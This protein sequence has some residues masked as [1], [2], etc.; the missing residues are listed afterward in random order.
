MVVSIIAKTFF[1]ARHG[2]ETLSQLIW[3]D[4]YATYNGGMLRILRKAIISDKPK[5]TYR[6]LMLDTARNFMPIQ[7]LRRVLDGMSSSKLNVFHWHIS[8]SQ[9]FPLKLPSLPQLALHGAYSSNMVYEPHEVNSH[10][11]LYID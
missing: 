11:F 4:E 10:S 8:D 2:L 3:W 5:F 9:S 6:G 1:G 7:D